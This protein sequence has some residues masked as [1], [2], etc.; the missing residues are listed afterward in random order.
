MAI[1][2]ITG[3]PGHGKSLLAITKGL[4]FVAE[5]REVFVSGFKD[6]DFKATGFKPLPSD[7][8][9]WQPEN[10]DDQGRQMPDW[11]LLPHGSV[12]MLDE[13]YDVLPQRSAGSKVPPHVDA[14]ARH[15]HYGYDIILVAQ[16]H[17]QL[18][19]FIKGLVDEHIHVRRKFGFGV[20]VLK[21]WDKF[22]ANTGA[23]D[24]LSAPKWKYP[25]K[26]FALYT[27]AT[28]HTV[29]RK[30][31]W[32]VY[33]V[34]V[35]LALIIGLVW[36]AKSR[37]QA[38]GGPTGAA[39][40]ATGGATSARAAGAKEADEALRRADYA[41][42]MRPRING[43]PWTAPVWDDLQPQ[44]VPDIYCI[45]VEDGGCSCVT[46]QGTKYTVEPK[47]CRAIARDGIYNPF[48]K[49]IDGERRESLASRD[50]GRDRDGVSQ[51]AGAV[52]ASM[53]APTSGYGSKRSIPQAYQPPELTVA[54][55]GSM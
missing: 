18:D 53:P 8:T 13:C 48:R 34:P 19:G 40:A 11:Q 50:D 12:I 30:I 6:I 20:A 14:L 16:M 44:G 45:A 9:A 27:S 54:A 22:Q 32:F 43:Q 38:M 52:E 51:A 55:K 37:M 31:P 17:N 23:T 41:A 39:S 26:N 15:R 2:L 49:P 35:L 1:T 3:Q 28:K 24:Y 4:A 36:F 42:W 7:F 25:S 29:K 47:I 5:G 33:A 10:K 46:E 21:T